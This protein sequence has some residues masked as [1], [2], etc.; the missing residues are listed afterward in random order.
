MTEQVTSKSAQVVVNSQGAQFTVTSILEP[1]IRY[2]NPSWELRCPL[3][4]HT[5]VWL[6]NLHPSNH[7]LWNHWANER[8]RWYLVLTCRLLMK[9]RLKVME[10]CDL[11]VNQTSKIHM[12]WWLYMQKKK[13]PK[14]LSWMTSSSSDWLLSLG[15]TWWR[16]CQLN[17]RSVKTAHGTMALYSLLEDLGELLKNFFKNLMANTSLRICWKIRRGAVKNSLMM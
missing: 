12:R 11:T 2:N 15:C 7:G 3:F 14:E 9:Q 8:P 6:L 17:V 5:Q 1:V 16:R 13:N 10:N 4:I